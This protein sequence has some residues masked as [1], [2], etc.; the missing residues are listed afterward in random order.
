M[1]NEITVVTQLRAVIDA[2]LNPTP[3][4]GETPAEN[5][6]VI[7]GFPSVDNMPARNTVYLLQ[8]HAEYENFATTNDRANL[9]VTMWILCKRAPKADLVT[10]AY[11]VQNDI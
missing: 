10:K 7:I 11:S 3:A 4:Q 9:T 6:P 5:I 2:G 8:D 1:T